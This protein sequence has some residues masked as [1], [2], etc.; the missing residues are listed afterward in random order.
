MNFGIFTDFHIREG[1]THADAFDENFSKVEAAEELGLDSVWLGEYHFSPDRSVMASPL[2]I[3]SSI[4][5]RTKR[6]RVGGAV[7]VVPLSNP[8]SLAEQGATIDHISK[9]RLDFGVG[10]SGLTQFYQ[11][12]NIDYAETRDRFSEGLDVIIKAWTN[13][14]FSHKGKY[15]TFED[16]TVVPKPYQ[17]PY[18]P[19]RIAASSPET[20]PMLGR[21]G[22]PIFIAGVGFGLDVVKE[23]LKEYRQAKQDAGHT[24]PDDVVLRVGAYLAETAEMARAEPE[25]S[26]LSSQ[27]QVS[28]LMKKYAPSQQSYEAGEAMASD[29]YDDILKK[30]IIVG[31]P[32]YIVER[33]QEYQEA[34]G[35]SGVILEVNY[36]GQIPYDRVVNCMRLL[37]EKVM[38]QFK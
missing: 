22:H 2:A 6:I 30:R 8:L 19:I 16:V 25:A 10:R 28:A 1:K 18:P 29:S 27:R 5:A 3:A 7:F 4:A 23:R 15:W 31:T 14:T 9:G 17:V 12:Y 26:I 32:E 35:I 34:L 36:G 11:G 33:L 13:D 24:E 20:Y 38:P 21:M 37:A